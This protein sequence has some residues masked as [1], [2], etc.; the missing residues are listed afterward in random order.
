MNS[1]TF[2]VDT[3]IP[4]PLKNYLQENCGVSSGLLRRLKNQG[5][6]A[7]NGEFA[8]TVDMVSMGD[9]ITLTETGE[10]TA[11]PNPDLN[12]T[13]AFENEAVVVF[14][15]PSG[16]P[17]HQ[18]T[19][20]RDDTLANFF[21]S[22]Y[23]N[24]VFRAVNRLDRD[25]SGLC[26]VAKNSHTA[27][28]LQGKPHK[29]YYAVVQGSTA[30][31]GTIDAP[32]ARLAESIIT[33]CVRDDGQRAVTHYKKIRE[34][35]GYSLLE[36]DLETGRTHQ[37]RVHFSHIG[38]PLAG[39]DLYG[40]SREFIGRQALH[41]GELSFV[42]PLTKEKITVKAPLPDDIEGLLQEKGK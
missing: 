39:D 2:I 27:N 19:R 3:E 16:M 38:Y 14:D 8:R 36:I 32:I 10:C 33:R 13:I 6:I 18:S 9:I 23:P 1:L 41:C 5:G 15:K 20:H 25:T 17:V 34:S 11:E 26:L 30:E 31:S 42:C 35:N 7:V 21:A 29:L 22:R 12:V 40:G 37:I 24:L 4:R 28:I